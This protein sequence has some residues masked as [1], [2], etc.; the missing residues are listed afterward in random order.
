MRIK[1]LQRR[2][3][4][5]PIPQEHE[6]RQR[7]WRVV[8]AAYAERPPS[9]AHGSTPKRLAVALVTAAIVLGIVLTPAGAKVID[10]VGDAVAPGARHPEP[11]LTHLPGGGSLLVESGGPWVVNADGSKRRLGDYGQAS[12]SAGG[13]FVAVADGHELKAVEPTGTDL[14]RWSIPSDR[15]VTHPSW[16]SSGVQVAYLSGDSLRVVAGNGVDDHLVAR[17]VSPVTPEWRPQQQPLP[18]DF[19]ASGPGTN[20]LAYVT[21]GGRV[22]VQNTA[23]DKVIF[24]SHASAP[25]EG[26]SWSSDGQLL[27]SFS[28]HGLI[29]YDMNDPD[30]IPIA[31]GMPARLSL[32][33]AVFAPRGD[34]V[35]AITRR[36][37]PSGPHSALIVSR[38][39]TDDFITKRVFSGPGRFTDLAW[40]PRGDWLLFG[41]SDADQWVFFNPNTR[42]ITPIGDITGQ[43]DAAA[44]GSAAFPRV[45]GWCCTP[46][47]TNSP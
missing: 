5:A 44:T 43:F 12:W 18:P 8:R 40:S 22:V 13:R 4:S 26:L 32:E 1:D 21:N 7:G 9:T 19:V 27:I 36:H 10:L 46:L 34:R 24:R 33:A 25:S 15:R 30:R 47:G 29:T 28:H 37:E 20:V 42:R 11:T 14:V 3:R 39:G 41:W 31:D 2:L 45:A 17:H 6:A 16:S 23:S 38:P 35:A